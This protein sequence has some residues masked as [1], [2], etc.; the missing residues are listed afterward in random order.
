[1]PIVLSEKFFFQV[2]PILRMNDFGDERQDR[3]VQ[4]FFAAYSVTSSMQITGFYNGNFTDE[5]HQVSA[6]L[7]VFL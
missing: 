5:I 2:T 4:E 3:Y 1:M 7:T 6:G